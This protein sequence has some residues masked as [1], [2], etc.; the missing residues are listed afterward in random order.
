MYSFFSSSKNY[1]A[2]FSSSKNYLA[3]SPHLS[4]YIILNKFMIHNI[5]GILM[6]MEFNNTITGDEK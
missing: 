3:F 4:L 6:N 1:L 5:E 2:F